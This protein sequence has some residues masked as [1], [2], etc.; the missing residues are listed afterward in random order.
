M[1]VKLSISLVASFLTAAS[2]ASSAQ[3]CL[4]A[5]SAEGITEPVALIATATN[6]AAAKAL[7]GSSGSGCLEIAEGKGKPPKVTSGS[8]SWTFTV[9]NSAE[10]VL[11]CRTYWSDECGNSF[12]FVIDDG[13]PFVFGEDSTFKCWHWVQSPKRLKQLKLEPGSHKLT[14]KNREDGV[15]LDQIL[16]TDDRKYCPVG[17][18]AVTVQA[19]S[20]TNAPAGST[21]EQK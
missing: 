8:A 21:R 18:E 17:I 5:E 13:Q 12:S 1:K 10:Y 19:A 15:A 2:F 9:T 20:S 3:V 11:W 7:P 14:L 6:N 16:I 4:E